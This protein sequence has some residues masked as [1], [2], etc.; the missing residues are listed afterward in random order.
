MYGSKDMIVTDSDQK[1]KRLYVETSVGQIHVTQGKPRSSTTTEIPILLLHLSPNSSQMFHAL[2]PKLAETRLVIAPDTP[3]FGMSDKP[4][5][6]PLVEDF[7]R[8]MIEMLDQLD[9]EQVDILGYHTGAMTATEMAIIASKRVRSLCIIGIPIFNQEEKDAYFKNPWP[10]PMSPTDTNYVSDQWK[11]SVAWR[12]PGQTLEMIKG[13]FMA[14][15]QAGDTGWWGPRAA[16]L[17]PMRDKLPLVNQPILPV[18]PKDDLWE[19]SPRAKDLLSNE[20][21]N[22]PD[23]GFGFVEISPEKV[24][25][26]LNDFQKDW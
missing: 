20:I 3:G 18:N 23:Y 11:I 5:E 2:L 19:I 1:V 13:T 7:A 4:S 24:I 12:G 10:A 8:W 15:L 16:F 9:I 21:I 14:K 22:L 6:P 17:Y 26:M 25:S